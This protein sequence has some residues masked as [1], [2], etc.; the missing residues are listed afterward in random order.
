M[1]RLVT[2][3][4]SV[5]AITVAA[6]SL[7]ACSSGA[8]SPSSTSTSASVDVAT[9]TVTPGKLTIATGSPAYSPWVE[10]ND[11]SSGQGFEAA[12]AYAVAGKLGFTNDQVVWTSTDFDSAITPGAKPWDLNLQ[13]F[14]ITD[15]R[16]KAV[17]FST[18][19]YTA[20]Q[21]VVT[22]KGSPADGK[23]SIADL[24]G[25]KIGVT[26]GTTSLTTVQNEIAPTTEASQFNTE[27]DTVQALKSKQ[28]DAIVVNLPEAYYI[29]NAELD[30]GVIVGQLSDAGQA[31][32]LGIVLQKGSA[33]TAPVSAAVDALRADGTLDKLAS[34]WLS[35]GGQEIVVLK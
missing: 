24:K 8:A 13:Q 34:K 12:V 3:L 30:N 29:T 19:Y 33:L 23:T 7:A 31:D 15:E 6:I 18:P 32:A 14:S 5:A 27:A 21:A 17:D 16:K 2:R 35:F 9:L 20:T 28:V 11:P 1:S 22:Y 10:N 26:A 25:L 4:A